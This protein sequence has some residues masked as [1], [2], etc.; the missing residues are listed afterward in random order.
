MRT[1]Y[2]VMY[3]GVNYKIQEMS[4]KFSLFKHGCFKRKW[5]DS[6]STVYSDSWSIDYYPNKEKAIDKIMENKKIDRNQ[7]IARKGR[8]KKVYP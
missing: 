5:E 4:V 8:W 2:R 1:R 6:G 7:S 3:N